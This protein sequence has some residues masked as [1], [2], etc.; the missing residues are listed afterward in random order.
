MSEER[1]EDPSRLSP[2]YGDTSARL[3]V[4]LRS[5]DDTGIRGPRFSPSNVSTKGLLAC[6]EGPALDCGDGAVDEV[7]NG[8]PGAG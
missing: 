6:G 1:C 3:L 5:G 7:S 4:K 2:V 8:S